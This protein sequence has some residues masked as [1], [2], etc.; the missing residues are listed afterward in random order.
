MNKIALF[1]F[2]VVFGLVATFALSYAQAQVIEVIQPTERFVRGVATSTA[3]MMTEVEWTTATQNSDILEELR[4]IR[5]ELRG[6]RQ[7]L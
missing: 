6:I 2:G 5:S 3:L 4:G 1:F 7:K